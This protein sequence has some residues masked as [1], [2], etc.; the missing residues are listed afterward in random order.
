MTVTQVA[1]LSGVYSMLTSN[2]YYLQK[3]KLVFITKQQSQ[4]SDK[5]NDE[6]CP[7]K[8]L[9][10]KNGYRYPGVIALK[11]FQ[12]PTRGDRKRLVLSL[13]RQTDS[14]FLQSHQKYC[15]YWEKYLISQRNSIYYSN[16]VVTI[17]TYRKN[18]RKYLQIN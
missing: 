14:S 1:Y 5:Y 10:D 13:F 7:M 8:R 11:N 6:H 15:N 17:R 2:F 3:Q 12:F 18:W 4:G 16:N 9:S